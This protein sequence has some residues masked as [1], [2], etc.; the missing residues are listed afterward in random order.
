MP[1]KSNNTVIINNKKNVH[2]QESKENKLQE[3]LNVAAN[4][5]L[6]KVNGSKKN[7]SKSDYYIDM[8]SKED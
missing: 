7:W 6:I 5:Q 4:S 1:I 8:L 2:I 3:K